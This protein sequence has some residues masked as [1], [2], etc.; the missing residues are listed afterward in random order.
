M[1]SSKIIEITTIAHHGLSHNPK[2]PLNMI[3]MNFKN[4]DEIVKYGVKRVGL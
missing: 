2:H 1:P 3:I 4:R